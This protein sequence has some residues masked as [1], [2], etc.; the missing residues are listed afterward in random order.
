VD[1]L[2]A[3]WRLKY[4]TAEKPQGCIF[5]DKPQAGDDAANHII[6]R[7]ERTFALLNAYP[8]NN[9]H[10]MVTP[11]AH[12]AHLEDVPTETIAELMSLCQLAVRALKRDFHPDGVNMGLNLGA[13]AGA[14]VK[15]HLHIHV[16]PR[17][18]GDTNF[19]PVTADVRVIPQSL[20]DSYRLLREAFEALR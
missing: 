14:G 11:Y 1:Q 18:A 8:Y 4:V 9:G 10:M 17:W 16:V 13:A 20:D 6:W 7:G 5:C 15:D 19:M 2:W 3:P 12:I